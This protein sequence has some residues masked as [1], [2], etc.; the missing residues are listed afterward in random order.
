LPEHFLGKSK[1][2]LTQEWYYLILLSIVLLV[3]F[4]RCSVAPVMREAERG[5][6]LKP[7]PF[8]HRKGREM[9]PA[10]WVAVVVCVLLISG[11]VL[12][13]AF[14]LRRVLRLSG[15]VAV[16]DNTDGSLDLTGDF[17]I[18]TSICY[19]S[20]TTG[21]YEQMIV[22]KTGWRFF[23]NTDSLGLRFH[24]GTNTHASY[25]SV[26]A[27]SSNYGGTGDAWS[28]VAVSYNATTNTYAFYVDNESVGTASG[29]ATPGD[30]GDSLFIGDNAAK[31]RGFHG[32][33]D[34]VRI[35]DE[36]LTNFPDSVTSDSLTVVE[37]ITQALWNFNEESGP[38]LDLAGDNDGT[39]QGDVTRV[40]EDAAGKSD[41]LA[42]FTAVQAEVGL[43]PDDYSLS[44]NFPNPFNPQ[45][46]I[47][48][49][50]PEASNVKLTVYNA[51]GQIVQV[52]V[53][54]EMKAGTRT[55]T[56]DARGLGSGIYLY[57]LK[58][59]TFIRTRKMVKIE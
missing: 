55:A 57:R 50:L 18:Q 30:N 20:D 17:T 11:L 28:H 48:Y 42:S 59:G 46:T 2:V 47:T 12:D 43:K 15:C 41:T 53:D 52:L 37:D 51:A 19:S 39:L 58:A 33:M 29:G 24:D 7:T 49:Q 1:K 21:Y 10:Y 22:T 9:K 5:P 27:P 34:D 40:L 35:S 45:T 26:V 3:R 44:Q 4:L 8:F 14:A 23:V 36:V 25:D 16:P 13:D 56:W 6:G 54:A 38:A 32:Y 31:N